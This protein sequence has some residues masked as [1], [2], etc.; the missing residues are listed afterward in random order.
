MNYPP[1]N[2][3]PY[4]VTPLTGFRNLR[5]FSGLTLHLAFF[6][7]PAERYRLIIQDFLD[8]S[9]RVIRLQ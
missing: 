4:A 5:Q 3:T 7:C 8:S 1:Q 6:E 2:Q 9:I